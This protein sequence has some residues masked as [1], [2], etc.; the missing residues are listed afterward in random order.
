MID[1]LHWGAFHYLSTIILP[2]CFNLFTIIFVCV[3]I[4]LNQ[5][6]TVPTNS[7]PIVMLFF[8]YLEGMAEFVCYYL[9]E[10]GPEEL[11]ADRHWKFLVPFVVISYPVYFIFKIP[12][13]IIRLF[14]IFGSPGS[15]WEKAFS[16]SCY[17]IYY[18][19]YSNNENCISFTLRLIYIGIPFFIFALIYVILMIALSPLWLFVFSPI[20][21]DCF[22]IGACI[23]LLSSEEDTVTTEERTNRVYYE[24]Q[25]VMLSRS[26]TGLIFMCCHLGLTGTHWCSIILLVFFVLSLILNII[27][28]VRATPEKCKEG[29]C[30][31]SNTI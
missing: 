4:D 21:L 22:G 27:Y 14:E 16:D 9:A 28:V 12:F 29:C 8:L 5:L 1:N 30:K 2:F 3:V 18:L 7:I 20:G 6:P 17:S 19:A 10:N 31:C 25:V 15:I 24:N 11:F 26:L 13:I 23:T